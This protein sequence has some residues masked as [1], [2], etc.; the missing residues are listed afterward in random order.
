MKIHL[1][2]VDETFVWQEALEVSVAE[3]D[4]PEL[5]RLGKI[6]CRGE[7]RRMAEGFLLQAAM[8]YEQRLRCMRCLRPVAVPFSGELDL[9]LQVGG[10]Q[11]AGSERELE[12]GDFSLLLL[13]EEIIDTRPLLI[14]QVQL[15][16]PMKPLCK[17]DC[18]G[19]CATCGVDLNSGSCDCQ[20]QAD[21]RWAA[22]AALKPQGE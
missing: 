4:L 19:L 11:A 1:D 15:N 7:I 10:P 18:A 3:L 22:L 12:A 13:E 9:I 6:E 5:V 20:R 14:E 16:I 21:P 17:E 2:Q 8:S